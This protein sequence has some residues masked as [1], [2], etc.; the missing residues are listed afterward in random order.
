MIYSF[1][2]FVYRIPAYPLEALTKKD[3]TG[4]IDQYLASFFRQPGFM[5]AMYMASPEFTKEI[6]LFLEG[7]ITETKRLNKFR[8]TALK[9]IGRMASRPTPFGLFSGC[10]V[11]VF[12]DEELVN[13]EPGQALVPRVRIDMGLLMSF[14][15]YIITDRE[16]RNVLTY[17]TNN[18]I[19]RF[20]NK[21]RY[22]EYTM[23]EGEKL[24]NLSSFEANEYL[25][26]ILHLSRKG[27]GLAEYIAELA[28]EEVTAEDVTEFVHEL[29]DSKILITELEP[30]MTGVEYDQQIYQFLE[31]KAG[32]TDLDEKTRSFF[33][34]SI[35]LFA[36]VRRRI[37]AIHNSSATP[38]HTQ[39]EEIT[40]IL[41]E[42]NTHYPVK[43]FLQLDSYVSQT[44]N[45]PRLTRALL[46]DVIEG[47]GIVSRFC[48]HSLNGTLIEFKRKFREKYEGRRVKLAEV[49]DPEAGIGYGN[50]NNEMLD[51]TPFV[52]EMPVGAPPASNRRSLSW[53]TDL[54]SLI[55]D[56]TLEAKKNGERKVQLSKSDIELLK[57]KVDLLPP[58]FNAFVSVSYDENGRHMIYYHQVGAT[59]ASCLLGR[60]GFLDKK[61]EGL[62]A[63]I[64]KNEAGY[65]GEKIVAEINHL[66]ESRVGNVMLR[67]KTRDYEICYLTKSNLDEGG[68]IEIDDLYLYLDGNNLVLY[69]ATLDKEIVPRLSNA[70]NYYKDT[71][72]VYKF[73]SDLQ[74]EETEGYLSLVTDI[75]PVPELV[76]FIPRI[77]YNNHIIWPAHW[78]I[79]T[80]DIRKFFE[81]P[82]PAFLKSM[83]EYLQSKN[84]P[85][86]FFLTNRENDLFVD[87][88]NL[89]SLK[90][91]VEEI[92]NMP[93][94]SIKE[95]FHQRGSRHL[96]RNAEG[97]FLH[98]LIIPLSKEAPKKV[99][100]PAAAKE[101]FADYVQEQQ[102]VKRTFYPGDEWVYFKV[103][104]GVKVSEK[105]L[106]SAIGPFIEFLREAGLIDSWFFIRYTDPAFHLRIRLHVTDKKHYSAVIENFSL[107]FKD[108]L[109]SNSI[110]NV[111][112]DTYI[113]EL[114]RYGFDL[115]PQ[116][117]RIFEAD[118]DFCVNALDEIETR[119][120]GSRKWLYVLAVIDAYLDVFEINE[121]AKL[122]FA[123]RIRDVFSIEFNANKMQRRYFSAKYRAS[124]EL[125]DT[126]LDER[127]IENE[128]PEWFLTLLSNFR[129]RLSAVYQAHYR[130]LNADKKTGY[131]NSFIHMSV[132]RFFSSK[133]RQHEYALYSLLEQYYRYKIGKNKY[134]KNEE[135][136]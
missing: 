49:L 50:A 39:Y 79:K 38:G 128:R 20:G 70:H 97:N 25:E 21:Y 116:A 19:Y 86:W 46:K 22:V 108:Y 105:I 85:E 29:I 33:N 125:I 45:N 15:E 1:D 135:P 53:Q 65:Y 106:S 35:G 36:E 120:L 126:F 7:Q 56:K 60:F 74:E 42:L 41:G 84:I 119:N 99:I 64:H 12:G 54:H 16:L 82:A 31:K 23:K 107:Y 24:Y 87:S 2:R 27:A 66:S 78:Y 113:R 34:K 4:D 133:N 134:V 71:L 111:V 98:E 43:H 114:E 17:Y 30:Y 6:P 57:P 11:G 8:S 110:K 115:T 3:E 9:Y 18:T 90:I 123:K 94:V 112:L 48:T 129:Y 44:D 96:I 14:A 76:D 100:K 5:E 81:L 72:P 55:L 58:T 136:V 93:R 132:D 77:E 32:R 28:S 67:P 118:S 47:V 52:D 80:D 91:F 103:Y 88:S 10:G 13:P 102:S 26:R 121:E 127:T 117:E 89:H 69:S 61:L 92:K 62:I 37:D 109:D 101:S 40:A 104:A 63:D 75:G 83:Q 73:L 124:K 95:S 131:L 59:S 130:E 51:I 68:K 122:D